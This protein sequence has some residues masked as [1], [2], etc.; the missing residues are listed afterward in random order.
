M[1]DMTAEKTVQQQGANRA[2]ARWF[3]WV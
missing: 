1:N 3:R 2:G